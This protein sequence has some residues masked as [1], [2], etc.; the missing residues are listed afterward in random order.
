M[1]YCMNPPGSFLGGAADGQAVDF[2][3]GNADADGHGLSIFAA[4]ADAFVEFQIVADHGDAGQDVGA[5]ADQRRAL[6]GGGDVP[7]SIR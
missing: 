6:D 7:S 5:V 1:F 4:G 3:R 2:Q